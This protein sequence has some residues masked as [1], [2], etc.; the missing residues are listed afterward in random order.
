[1]NILSTPSPAGS[2]NVQQIN[3]ERRPEAF[4]N[5]KKVK[6]APHQQVN[7]ISSQLLN[8]LVS[9]SPISTKSIVRTPPDKMPES[10]SSRITIMDSGQK[11]D[12]QTAW[13]EIEHYLNLIG[14]SP[15]HMQEVQHNLQELTVNKFQYLEDLVDHLISDLNE[16]EGTQ[17]PLTDEIGDDNHASRGAGAGGKLYSFAK[18]AIAALASQ[19]A[20]SYMTPMASASSL[21]GST[22]MAGQVKPQANADSPAAGVAGIM[23]NDPARA[24]LLQKVESNGTEALLKR[25]PERLH[26]HQPAQVTNSISSGDDGPS[27]ET[28]RDLVD[29]LLSNRPFPELSSFK[30]FRPISR[31]QTIDKGLGPDELTQDGK[32]VRLGAEFGELLVEKKTRRG[33]T[34]YR[35]KN[36]HTSGPDGIT[37]KPR[38][39]VELSNCF[40]P[41]SKGDNLAGTSWQNNPEL[42]KMT[43]AYMNACDG[44]GKYH[45]QGEFDI[46][47]NMR[48]P[49]NATVFRLMPHSDGLQYIDSS[50]KIQRLSIDGSTVDDYISLQ[51]NGAQFEGPGDSPLTMRVE[52]RDGQHYFNVLVRSDVTPFK[53][54]DNH[55][56]FPLESAKD[57]GKAKCCNGENQMQQVRHIYAEP[58][59]SG[60]FHVRFHAQFTYYWSNSDVYDPEY[61]NFG[62]ND[63]ESV[64]S[65]S[66]IGNNNRDSKSTPSGYHAQFGISDASDS[67]VYVRIKNPDVKPARSRFALSSILDDGKTQNVIGGCP[68]Y[69]YLFKDKFLCPDQNWAE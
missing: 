5:G 46:S 64:F 59:K 65:F 22:K 8:M 58:L 60:W 6:E 41:I 12:I 43:G 14:L 52:Y 29:K 32:F 39:N 16:Q 26:Q 45:Y 18:F 35:F 69:C 4:S 3:D 34:I 37:L 44:L 51:N 25:R 1:M 31:P 11:L 15:E 38:E 24:R 33:D 56:D 36:Q 23:A 55:C 53:R 9:D 20:L 54:T 49:G 63:E 61:I 62:I 66:S 21:S 17:Y 7:N 30:R 42:A 47:I 50:N 48:T 57:V 68:M 27:S 28:D 19:S 2:L 13:V 40:Y 10:I 67:S